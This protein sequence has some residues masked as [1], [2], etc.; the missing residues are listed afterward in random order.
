MSNAFLDGIRSLANERDISEAELVEA[1]EQALSVAYRKY[2]GLEIEVNLRLDSKVKSGVV[3]DKEVVGEVLEPAAQ[4]ALVE[5]LKLN[6]DVE[7]GDTVPV[8]TD[9]TLF[10]RIASQSF[11]QVLN[12]RMREAELRQVHETF[13]ERINDIMSATVLRREDQ[14]VVLQVNR[15]EVR[16]PRR[17]QVQS[18]DYRANERMKV[19]IVKIEEGYRGFE[20]IV[21]RS[22]PTL[23]RRLL[24]LEVPEIAEGLVE[25]MG[26]SREP[27]QRTKIS[28][29]SRDERIDAVGACVGQRGARIQAIMNELRPEK[30]DIIPWSEDPI[31]YIQNALNPA[32]VQSIHL[33]HESKTATVSVH[34]SQQSLAIGKQ[35]QNVRLASRLTEWRIDIRSENESGMEEAQGRRRPEGP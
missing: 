35:G 19:L 13:S 4:I 10:G 21:S 12:Q 28:V 31:E 17:E 23:V 7:I 33:D 8:Q 14:N 1:F 20:V 5:A 11:K 22:H 29:V 16:L 34:E 6:P 30:I 32:K 2:K 18:D 3:V 25:I 15:H 26:I 24:E 9:P 27:G